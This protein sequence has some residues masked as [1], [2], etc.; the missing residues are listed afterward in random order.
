MRFWKVQASGNDFVL[1]DCR[2]DK[3]TKAWYSRFAR[4]RCDRKFGVGA[5]G[6]L[7]AETVTGGGLRMRI[8]NADGS[9]AEMC[10]NGARCFALWANGTRGRGTMSFE[11]LAGTIQA[12]IGAVKSGIGQAAVRLSDPFGLKMGIP[13]KVLGKDIHVH[14][15]NT[16]VPHAV[17]FVADVNGIDVKTI[18]Q[19]L[20]YHKAF[21]PA[22]TNVNFV[23]CTGKDT[24]RIRTYE[25][26]V[27]DETLACGTGT[28]ASA[29]VSALTVNDSRKKYAVTVTTQSGE[30]LRVRFGKT[31]NSISDVW[32]Q[33]KTQ[34][35]FEGNLC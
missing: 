14:H 11:T 10:G 6:V 3:K 30:T 1:I 32:F 29:I 17:V 12:E 18:G 27:E 33:G 22:G 2:K 23:E 21:S 24:I 19:A 35:V 28:C 5:D 13:L 4:V 8:F 34:I 25:R 15:I 31:E 16:G 9:E 20:R 26:G 7:V